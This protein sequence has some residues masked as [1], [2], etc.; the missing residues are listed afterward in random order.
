MPN[1]QVV[2]KLADARLAFI[3][4]QKIDRAR[5]LNHQVGQWSNN[6]NAADF[7]A[8]IAKNGPGKYDVLLPSDI[9]GRSFLPNGTEVN[10]D[11]ARIIVKPNGAV[12]TAFPY[13]SGFKN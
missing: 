3:N 5:S 8:G 13:N 2:Q 11:M 10:V 12:R 4:G 9:S 7:I 6:Q 1:N